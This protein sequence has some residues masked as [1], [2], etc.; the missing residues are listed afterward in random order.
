VRTCYAAFCYWLL[1]YCYLQR[2][3]SGWFQAPEIYETD[4]MVQC[5]DYLGKCT[6]CALKGC[7]IFHCVKCPISQFNQLD[8]CNYSSLLY[9]YW[10]SVY[11][12]NYWN[13]DVENSDFNCGF[14]YFTLSFC[15]ILLYVLLHFCI[16][17][18]KTLL[19]ETYI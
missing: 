19:L 1:I 11:F 2:T 17:Y 10:F 8:R 15:Q 14:V 18:F 13:K 7:G 4:F 3:Y 12:T 6:M 5:V 16:M 9:P